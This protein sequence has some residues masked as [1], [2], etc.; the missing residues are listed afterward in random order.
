VNISPLPVLKKCKE[1]IYSPKKGAIE[2]TFATNKKLNH[3]EFS[4]G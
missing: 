2:P 3:Q 1:G 4:S